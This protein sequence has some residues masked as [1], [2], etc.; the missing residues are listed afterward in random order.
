MNKGLFVCILALTLIIVF[1]TPLPVAAQQPRYRLIDMGTFGGPSSDVGGGGNGTSRVVNNRG[2]LTGWADS[3]VPDPFP[4]FCFNED[5]YVGHAFQW[6]AGIRTDLGALHDGLSSA[7][8]WI[9]ENGLIAGG[10]QNGEIDPLFPGLP[11][12][13]GVLWRNRRMTDLGTLPEGGYESWA[14]A[15]NSNGQVVGWANNLVPDANNSMAAPGLLPTQTRAFLWQGGVMQ[16]LGTLGGTDA[17]AQFINERGQVVGYSYIDT[18]PSSSCPYPLNTGSFIWDKK[19]GMVNLGS[20]GGTCTITSAINNRGQVVGESFAVGDQTAPAFIWDNGLFEPL[21]GSLGGDFTGAGAINDRGEATGFAYLSGNST[22]H[23]AL[24]KHIG[25]L[26][27]LG[28]VDGDL[29]SYASSINA[30]TQVVG[31]SAPDCD[32]G[33]TSTIRAFLWDQGSMFDLNS[34]I[35]P[36]SSLYLRFAETINDRG[37]IAGTGLDGSGHAHAF[38]LVP[39]GDNASDCEEVPAGEA[40]AAPVRSVPRAARPQF[41]D[42]GNSIRQRLHR[43][44]GPGVPLVRRQSFL[45][46]ESQM[47]ATSNDGSS[48]SSYPFIND[49]IEAM[50]VGAKQ[51]QLTCPARYNTCTPCSD[52]VKYCQIYIFPFGYRCLHLQC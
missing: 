36:G 40:L 9:S 35:L 2:T 27:D 20:F 18:T 1:T 42:P 19:H 11:E 52:H 44:L 28:T 46:G 33:D 30:Q 7:A 49:Q 51:T 8:Y 15:V 13:R 32:F 29:C 31:A 14:N 4:D 24:W 48:G 10:A 3:S 43:P 41:A 47:P 38:L 6:R 22:Y 25:E 21:G 16:D 12:T 23:A 34:L 45:N 26:T 37:E 39:C 5:C 50:E 17:L